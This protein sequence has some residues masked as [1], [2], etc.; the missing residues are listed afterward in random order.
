MSAAGAEVV[1]GCS[2]LVRSLRQRDLTAGNRNRCLQRKIDAL[3]APLDIE[4]IPPLAQRVETRL[5]IAFVF[6]RDDLLH[7]LRHRIRV[8]TQ[9][10]GLQRHLEQLHAPRQGA[11]PPCRLLLLPLRKSRLRRACRAGVVVHLRA[12]GDPPQRFVN[13]R[14]A[15]GLCPLSQ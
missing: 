11:R 6:K 8:E 15:R 2:T 3:V 7:P 1:Q 9:D 4:L 10:I 14:I 12:L 13:Q 5:R